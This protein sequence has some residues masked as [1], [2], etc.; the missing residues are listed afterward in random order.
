VFVGPMLATNVFVDPGNAV[1]YGMFVS[2]LPQGTN[3]EAQLEWTR[4]A[5][6]GTTI[7]T[8]ASPGT[9]PTSGSTPT[10]S[11]FMVGGDTT[12]QLHGA[13]EMS[14]S[15]IAPGEWCYVN[16]GTNLGA[17][18]VNVITGLTAN[19]FVWPTNDNNLVTWN[20]LTTTT[21]LGC[22]APLTVP[23]AGGVAL[24]K[25]TGGGAC[26]WNKLL[27]LPT[28]AVKGA[29]FRQSADGS[30]LA[31]V[32]YA[33]TIDFGGGPLTST[34][35]SSLAL[36]RFDANGT[37]VWAKSFGG[38]GSSFTVGSLGGNTAGD[39]LVT[40]RYAG[41]VDLGGG[42]L[43]ASADTFVAVFGAS[44]A[45]QWDKTVTVGGSGALVAS[46]GPCGVA[47]AT[48]SPSVNFGT[49]PL[50][51]IQNGVA[52]IGVAALGL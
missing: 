10:V 31:S 36:A 45:L 6:D 43:P 51:T 1:F 33:G 3:T 14:P 26:T 30:L 40:A 49:G 8:T 38:A 46:I 39:V 21:D 44:G 24:A 47:V 41:A 22:G 19:A 2:G 34:G 9:Y 42:A 5:P 20:P 23:A 27:D 11:H 52:S 32:V 16:D 37:L 4:L 28:A 50:S 48:N 12:N 25:F 35:S 15:V 29:A 7:F 17:S 13:F 18:A